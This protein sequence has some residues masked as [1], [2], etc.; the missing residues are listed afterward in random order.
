MSNQQR[1]QYKITPGALV[2]NEAELVG[3]V[4]IGVRTVVHP[5]AT[6]KAAKG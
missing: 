1:T 6:I 3:D 5:K 4:A 2:C